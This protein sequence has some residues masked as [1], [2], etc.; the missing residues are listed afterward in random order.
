MIKIAQ[1]A[2]AIVY[3]N[4]NIIIK[5]RFSKE[6]RLPQIDQALRQFRTRREAKV[7]QKLEEMQFPAPHLLDFCDK[8]MS[9]TMDFVP[10]EK[11]RDVLKQSDDFQI[12]A[13]EMGLRIG[14][15]HQHDMVHGDLT[16][17]NMIKHQATGNVHLIDFGLSFFSDKDED[18]AVDLFLFERALASTHY[19]YYPEIFNKALDGYKKAYPE[20][21]SVLARLEQVKK[22]GRNKKR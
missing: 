14:K 2:E 5:E 22:R 1:G 18:K 3:K 20:Y 4:N 17:S 9:I 10:G 8:R 16:T 21:A 15:F 13:Q 11:L 12:L 19:E 6:Y 7:L